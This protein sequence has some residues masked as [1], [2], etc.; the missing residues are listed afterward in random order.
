MTLGRARGGVDVVAA[1]EGAVLEGLG[2]GQ[3]GEVLVAEGD[4]LAFGHQ[5]GELRLAGVGELTQ[6]DAADFRARGG[7]DIRYRG[8]SSE[9][10]GVG[11]VG[12]LAHVVVLEGLEGRVLLLGVPGRE[13]VRVLWEK[14][15]V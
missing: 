10:L 5:V 2:D 4:D 7:R 3:G 12:V 9:D 1:K 15:L 6:L 8:G 11:G 13:V 14:G